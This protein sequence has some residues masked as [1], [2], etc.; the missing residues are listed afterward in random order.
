MKYAMDARISPSTISFDLDHLSLTIPEAGL[1]RM[2]VM[3]MLATAKPI[4]TGS[5]LIFDAYCGIRGTTTWTIVKNS[6]VA[7]FT[8]H[9]T[10]T[11]LL[12]AR[13]FSNSAELS[14]A[15]ILMK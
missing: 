2:A 8:R 12:T 6:M 4:K 7:M 13:S 5:A 14:H 1:R 9:I 10:D 3:D 15:W 11:I